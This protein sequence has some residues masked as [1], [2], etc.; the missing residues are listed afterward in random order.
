[1]IDRPIITVREWA[2]AQ[3]PPVPDRTAKLWAETGH[4]PAYQSPARPGGTWLC[5]ADQPH[6]GLPRRG[7][8]PRGA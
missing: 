4:L 7:R 2:A 8:P 3:R 1:M 5:R 6:P